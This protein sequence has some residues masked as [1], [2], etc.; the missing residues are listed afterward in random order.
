MNPVPVHGDAA[1][2]LKEIG[3]LI[4]ADLHIGIEHE[5]S[6][7]GV[8]LPSQMEGMVERL[9]A[10]ARA[11]KA[12]RL[13]MVGDLKHNLP[14]SSRQEAL[15]VPRF[16]E[17]LHRIFDEIDM[18]KGNHDGGIERLLP[19][20]VRM[21]PSTGVRIGGYGIC[22]GHSWPSPKVMDAD[23]LLIAHSHP[24]VMLRDALGHTWT[25]RCWLR[26]TF[27]G[28]KRYPGTEGRAVVI[29]AYNPYCRGHPCNLEG[30]RLIGPLFRNVIIDLDAAEIYLLD[31]TFLGRRGRL[32]VTR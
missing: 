2:L 22:H 13:V 5:M 21:H 18:V 6:S 25:E 1:L 19:T 30:G 11:A 15:E 9:S 32:L 14:R 26:T 4:V 3:A 10:L 8:T 27:S 20:Y 16:L 12:R 31:S 23:I 29:P 24:V 7:M 17:C 28:G